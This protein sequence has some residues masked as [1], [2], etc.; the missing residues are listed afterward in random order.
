MTSPIS[1][2]SRQ[3]QVD[4]LARKTADETQDKA[5]QAAAQ[6]STGTPA[7]EDDMLQ[8]SEAAL[9]AMEEPAFDRTRVD[10]IKQ[11]IADNG[12]PIDPRR[13]AEQFVAIEKMIK[14]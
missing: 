14:D 3:N 10:A 9:K 6:K 4:A 1:A 13:I 12:Y 7:L 11:S 2:F 5:E 8:L